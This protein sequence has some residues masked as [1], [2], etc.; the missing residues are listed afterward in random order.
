MHSPGL[1]DCE[2]RSSQCIEAADRSMPSAVT[3]RQFAGTLGSVLLGGALPALP[4][5]S[6]QGTQEGLGSRP[7]LIED[8]DWQELQARYRNVIRVYGSRLSGAQRH[9]LGQVLTT[10][11]RMLA[12]I[13]AFIVQNQDVSACTF[14]P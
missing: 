5:T 2:D 12:S 6:F 4:A 1:P 11:Q 7:H 9:S 13:R 8:A 10:N 14:R 3:R